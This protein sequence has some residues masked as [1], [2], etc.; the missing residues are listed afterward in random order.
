MGTSRRRGIGGYRETQQHGESLETGRVLPLNR[1]Q[2]DPDQPRKTRSEEGMAALTSSVRTF[3][4]LQP[5][6]VRYDKERDVYVIVIGE[7]R[8]AAAHE[9]ELATVPVIVTEATSPAAFAIQMTENTIRE[10][11]P[12]L[13]TIRGFRVLLDQFSRKQLRDMGWN[14][15]VLTRWISVAEHPEITVNGQGLWE[16]ASQAGI[17]AAYE[18]VVDLNRLSGETRGRP[19]GAGQEG[20]TNVAPMTLDVAHTAPQVLTEQGMPPAAATRQPV[21]SAVSS[22]EPERRTR[23]VPHDTTHSP[24]GLTLVVDHRATTAEEWVESLDGWLTALTNPVGQSWLAALP[25]AERDTIA[26]KLATLLSVVDPV[27]LTS[28]S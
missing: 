2:P 20:G 6:V 27:D 25:A 23:P 1:I 9:A 12:T 18:Q 13:D 5:L 28:G 15:S 11:M 21:G 16:Y 26:G 17:R 7:R 24:T 22:G 10:A 3:G 4:I 8:Y 19:S 14:N